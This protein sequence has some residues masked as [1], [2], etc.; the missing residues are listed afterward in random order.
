M[1]TVSPLRILRYARIITIGGLV[2]SSSF[3]AHGMLIVLLSETPAFASS[4]Y[5]INHPDLLLWL[6]TDSLTN[7]L[8]GESVTSWPSVDNELSA[9]VYSGSTGPSLTTNAV[10]GWDAVY[11]D[12]SNDF[13]DIVGFFDDNGLATNG[14]SVFMVTKSD[15][16]YFGVSGNQASGGGGAPRLYLTRQ[17]FTCNELTDR[18][19]SSTSSGE[20]Q[21]HCAEYDGDGTMALYVDGE[22]IDQKEIGT[23]S[24]FG[25][26]G[27]LAIPFQSGGNH[28]GYLAEL[29]IL[30]GIP[31][32]FTFDEITAYLNAKYISS[33]SPCS[34]SQYTANVD[35]DEVFV[36]P[37]RVSKNCY[38]AQDVETKQ[39]LQQRPLSDTEVSGFISFQTT[40]G[41]VEV[42][43]TV[44][45]PIEQALIYPVSCN[46]S[47]VTN[48][49]TNLT[50]TL[51]WP[52][53]YVLDVY[54]NRQH[55]LH[56]FANPIPDNIN[57]Q[58]PNVVYFGPGMHYCD[59]IVLTNNQTLYLDEGCVL[60]SRVESTEATNIT[61]CGSGILDGSLWPGW[62]EPKNSGWPSIALMGCQNVVIKDIIIRD[63]PNW[64]VAPV[65]C[66]NVLVDNLKM[67]NWR[68]HSDGIDLLN[69]RYVN[70]RNSFF[71]T[72]N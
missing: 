57:V 14:F 41:P 15:D 36:Y 24:D 5:D 44:S 16:P 35:G 63:S 20:I 62:F 58:D 37:V 11:F 47:V 8:P 55:A 23:F 52:G 68:W 31:D 49:S 3:L 46:V 38:S 21:V 70:I 61:I 54:T 7:Y 48:S 34:F 1:I 22:L 43:I 50:F 65:K 53:H 72:T 28:S 60:F 12:G 29:I 71:R 17:Y 33:A 39:V 19:T 32:D 51:P 27:S 67:I 26:T 59:T 25:S 10:N 4:Y 42:E 45:D 30:K 9:A 18:I 13:L 56:I 40:N 6:K 69:C 66:D 2:S 64:T